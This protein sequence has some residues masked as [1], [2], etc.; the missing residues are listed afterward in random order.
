MSN[1]K[2]STEASQLQKLLAPI[3]EQG[4]IDPF[5]AHQGRVLER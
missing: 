2:H 4:A 1:Q 3:R 5:A